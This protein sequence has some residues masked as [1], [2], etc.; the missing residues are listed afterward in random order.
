MQFVKLNLFP[1]KVVPKNAEG[2]S[3]NELKGNY[4]N[5]I[6]FRQLSRQREVCWDAGGDE[7]K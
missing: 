2:S 6:D 4:N 5:E 1:A 3:G 7:T